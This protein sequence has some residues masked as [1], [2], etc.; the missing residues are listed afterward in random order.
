MEAPSESHVIVSINCPNESAATFQNNEST[1]ERVSLFFW[2]LDAVP[3]GVVDP[4]MWKL[5][6]SSDIDAIVSML[7][8]HPECQRIVVH[9]S[10]GKSR[11]AAVGAALH[12]IF[13]GDD[14]IIFKDPRYFPNMRVYRMLLEAWYCDTRKE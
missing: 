7:R 3:E 4:E 2:D 5:C 1:V 12:K 14:S 13:N 9:C 8:S 6:E 11:S 10:A